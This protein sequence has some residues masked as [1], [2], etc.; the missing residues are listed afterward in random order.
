M[1]PARDRKLYRGAALEALIDAMRPKVD[2]QSRRLIAKGRTL[3]GIRVDE[4]VAAQASPE[5]RRALSRLM[6][7]RRWRY[8]PFVEFVA[9]LRSL[10]VRLFAALAEGS[11]DVCFVVDSLAKSSFWVVAMALILL[12]PA[13]YANL[14]LAVDDDGSGGGLFAAF[15][16]V[17]AD[18]RL[19]LMDD[20]AYSGDQLSYFH[21][22][23]VDQWA[24]A[25]PTKKGGVRVYVAVPFMSSPSI[26]LFGRRGRTTLLFEEKF[27]SLFYRRT[28]ASV[29]ASDVY[30]A[31]ESSILLSAKLE[32]RSLFFDFLGVL[33]T[34]TLIIFEHKVADSLS[35]PNRWLQLGPCLQ[36]QQSQQSSGMRVREDRAAELVALIKRDMRDRRGGWS[37]PLQ[38]HQQL[39][40]P[41]SASQRLMLAASRVVA[42]MFASSPKFRAEFGERV[43][44]E[45]DRPNPPAFFPLIPPEFCDPRYRRFVRQRLRRMSAAFVD[46]MPP[47]RRPPYKRSSFRRKIRRAA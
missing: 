38:Q 20:A 15:S 21:D 28:L 42:D 30:L 17:S 24:A 34:N 16:H 1:P 33:P 43:G 29:L 7:G 27:S 13:S 41:G 5:I 25:H 47:C 46:D 23:V 14:S 8:V 35:I 4:Y 26:P 31:R 39:N 9:K 3:P 40:G 11:G 37:S 22:L 32:Y 44:L 36:L 2:E 18:A 6:A 19:V 10:A 45:P 12:P